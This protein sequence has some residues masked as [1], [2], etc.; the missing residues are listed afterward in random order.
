MLIVE[1]EKWEREGL[2][3]FLDWTRFGFDTVETACDGIEGIEK[4]EKMRPDIILTDIKMPGMDG[5]K[6][7]KK[8]KN[9]LPKVKI[10][11]LTGYDDFRFAKEAID[12]NANAYI[13]KPFDEEDIIPA[14]QKVLNEYKS[15]S[16]REDMIKVALNESIR[17]SRTSF[18]TDLLEGRVDEREL[19]TQLTHHN[20]KISGDGQYL[21]SVIKLLNLSSLCND[22][23]VHDTNNNSRKT[24]DELQAFLDTENILTR[25][26]LFSLSDS[27]E[28]QIILCFQ[29]SLEKLVLLQSYLTNLLQ[30]IEETKRFPVKI[31]TGKPVKMIVDIKTSYT[32]ALHAVEFGAF[33]DLLGIID[34]A[35]V[36]RIEKEFSENAGEFMILCSYY[37]K[38][39][40]H[41]VRSSDEERL[42]G[43]LDEMF[44]HIHKNK[45]AGKELIVN[46]LQN[47]KNEATTFFYT[48]G[49]DFSQAVIGKEGFETDLLRCFNIQSLKNNVSDFFNNILLRMHEKDKNKDSQVIK[50]VTEFIEKRYMT[51]I[52]LKIIAKDVYLSPNYL[53]NVFKK[54]TGKT[55]NVYLCEYR[56]EKARE[57]LKSPKNKVNLVAA[58]V[59]I[60]NTSYFCTVFKETY[61]MAPG[62]YQETLLRNQ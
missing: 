56:M 19:L 27:V 41:A 57:L 2:L 3:N 38:Q 55:F 25:D 62:E 35:G 28:N 14:I 6:M 33:W 31:G 49:K 5:L 4:A 32:E 7:S 29:V 15:E 50:K 59:G 46:Y 1:D 43:I 26:L 45:G 61:G 8:I 20:I 17:T 48:L 21:V 10:I 24:L 16:E 36:E 42:L 54:C 23:I 39:L 18:I 11:I 30:K 51:E 47:V 40:L 52:S 53:G 12:F 13:L 44:L 37:S 34:Y 60:P 58:K 22:G 9:F